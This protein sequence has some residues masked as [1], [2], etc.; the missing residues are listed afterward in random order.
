[1]LKTPALV[2]GEPGLGKAD[3]AL[4]LHRIANRQQQ[5][6]FVTV[7][8]NT[9]PEGLLDAA[10]EAGGGTLLCERID[11][12]DGP[13]LREVS[14][15]Y[16]ARHIVRGLD[17][18]PLTARLMA[19]AEPGL[20]EKAKRGEF[21]EE[22]YSRMNIMPVFLPPLRDRRE[23]IVPAALRYASAR[24][25][26]S[27][28]DIQGFSEEARDILARQ[29]WKLNFRE[30]REAVEAAVDACPGGIVLPSYLGAVQLPG[31]SEPI[32]GSLRKMRAAY[33]RD[34]ARA[35]LNIHGN[36]VEGKRKAAAE[37]GVSL[38]T[39]YRILG[40]KK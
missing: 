15:L 22:L 3:F 36:T 40:S 21:P 26:L 18:K 38:S 39:L 2:I 7:N 31:S 27:G 6:P 25:T 12:W 19:T 28:K 1:M 16:V 37:M 29:D 32:A 34:H 11:R 10:L 8:V 14:N 24:A 13:L 30:L 35:M 5:R 17:V 33:G 4:A 9:T 23:D 20:A